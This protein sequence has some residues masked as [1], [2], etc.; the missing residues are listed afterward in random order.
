MASPSGGVLVVG[1]G[2]NGLIAAIHLA[3]AG[4]DVTVLEQAASPGG[5]TA[6][7]EVTLPGFVHDRCAGFAPMAIVNPA[8]RELEL[9]VEWVNPPVAMAHPFEDG[10]AMALHR[11]LAATVDSL[12]AAGAGWAGAMDRML[13]NATRLA[14]AIFAPLPPGREALRLV[15]GLRGA[16]PRWAWRLLASVQ[17]LGRDLF[18][19]DERATAWL[20]ASAQHSGL[21]PTTLGSGAFGFLLQLV[22]QSHGWPFPRGGMQT[23]VDALARRAGAHGAR[24]RC[25][26]A[27]DRVL[28][29]GGRV[30][31]VRLADGE[32]IGADAVLTTVSATVL[33]RMLPAG[34]LP[35]RLH[36]RLAGWRYA[37]AAFKV[38]YALSG[39]VPWTAPAARSAGVVHVA[40][41]L[42]ELTAAAQAA[43]RGEVP[44]RPAL[45]VGQ[46]TLHDP[47]RAPAGGHTLYVYG[48]VPQR[49]ELSDEAVAD[50]LQA[51]LERFA[52]GFSGLVR[53]R[54][55]RP[56]QQT[57]R[58]NPSLVGGDLGAGAMQ[59]DQQLVFRPAPR[60]CR[61]RTPLRGLYVA[62]GSVHPGPAVHGMTARGAARALLR[63]RRAAGL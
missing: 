51:Q 2:H 43:W 45:V 21:P 28:V 32:E 54:A 48:H 9:D 4:L 16:T 61:Y 11:D 29:R 37:T 31:G 1:A 13:P 23:L 58:E 12:G 42:D 62:G 50:R 3:A 38:D 7:G 63:D 26:A 8:L 53:A 10:S 22:G 40:G 24:L 47:A 56:P 18:A 41:E 59:L 30:A 19:G 52:P 5:A 36:R 6:S 35:G 17:T 25:G 20:S 33:A 44:E 55:I 46:H 14:A 57:E 60:M 49:Y 15:Q 34:A 27:V 39:P